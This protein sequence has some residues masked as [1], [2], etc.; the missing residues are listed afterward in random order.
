VAGLLDEHLLDLY[1]EVLELVARAPTSPSGA[2]EHA[3]DDLR[4]A[5]G[6]A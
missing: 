3:L 1:V 6:L 2:I 4:R 5:P